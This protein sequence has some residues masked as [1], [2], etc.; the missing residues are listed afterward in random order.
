MLNQSHDIVGLPVALDKTAQAFQLGPLKASGAFRHQ[1]CQSRIVELAILGVFIRRRR[2][3]FSSASRGERTHDFAKTSKK[4]IDV[5]IGESR[6]WRPCTMK[7]HFSPDRVLLNSENCVRFDELPVHNCVLDRFRDAAAGST[8]KQ[9]LDAIADFQITNVHR[10]ARETFFIIVTP[11]CQHRLEPMAT[12]S[13]HEEL[14]IVRR[15]LDEITMLCM[16]EGRAIERRNVMNCAAGPAPDVAILSHSFA[17]W[18]P[19]V[20]R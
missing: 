5:F 7:L 1:R 13:I 11:R 15:L 19:A 18:R 9:S 12:V 16:I 4:A 17:A 2:S 20:R 6:G 3:R 8:E 14:P 10:I